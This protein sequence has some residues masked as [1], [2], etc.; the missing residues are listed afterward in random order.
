MIRV[1]EFTAA[2]SPLQCREP[3]VGELISASGN[4]FG[5][6]SITF[7][8]HIAGKA[9]TLASWKNAVIMDISGA[10]GISGGP[11]FDP[12]GNVVAIFVGALRAGPSYVGMSVGIPGSTICSLMARA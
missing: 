7:W 8:G 9:R 10:P 2:S 12:A 6:E 5:V 11:V 3:Q 1:A 4:P